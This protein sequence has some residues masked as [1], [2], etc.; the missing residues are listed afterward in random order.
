MIIVD[1]NRF[2]EAYSGYQQE[3]AKQH[4]KAVELRKNAITPKNI[5]K[6]YGIP[7]R[8]LGHWFYHNKIPY[9]LQSI[10]FAKKM[11]WLP[12]KI[13]KT[14]KF[15]TILR[16]FAWI[17]G[18]G[19]LAK[20]GYMMFSDGEEENLELIGNE[21][22]ENLGLK[23]KISKYSGNLPGICNKLEI[24]GRGNRIFGR[25]IM[26]MD[27]PVGDKVSQSFL[28]PD[29]LINAPKWVKKEFLDVLLSN[30]IKAP[31]L[32]KSKIASIKSIPFRMNKVEELINMHKDFFNQIKTI[33]HKF[34]IDTS[35]IFMEK[36]FYKRHDNKRSYCL[37]FLILANQLNFL[38]FAKL[39]KFNYAKT[40][41]E[42]LKHVEKI[43]K[44]AVRR[45]LEI[46]RQY[47]KALEFKAQGYSFIKTAKLL[48]LKEGRVRSWFE[49]YE[50]RLY[51]VLGEIEKYVTTNPKK[52]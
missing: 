12:L 10:E 40:K 34:G 52:C 50:P 45:E 14:E 29:W 43:V 41:K 51:K 17:Y 26:A 24:Q 31:T 13:E 19:T 22:V 28:L 33:L 32:E 47:N 49:G 5:S 20:D 37:G 18:D 8:R 27:A 23:I 35:D 21:I 36:G 16:I 46:T 30:E 3:S 9:P 15:K 1:E 25:L 38:R 4:E 48:N 42:K 2:L 11:D 7:Y 39:F 44:K 6:Q